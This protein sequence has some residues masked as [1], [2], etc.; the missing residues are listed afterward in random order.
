MKTKIMVSMLVLLLGLGGAGFY[1]PAGDKEVA[2]AIKVIHEVSKKTGDID[3]TTAKKGDFLFSGDQVRT[4]A[5]SIA[6]VKFKDNS[7]LRVRE[8]TELK[9]YAEQKDGKLQKNVNVTRGQFTF[10]IQKQENEV[11][12]FTSPT[13]VAA[14]RGTAGNMGFNIDGDMI[15]VLHGLVNLFNS[16]SK[17]AVDVGE[18]QTG[19]S[20]KDGTIYVR[21]A[22]QNEKDDA[23]NSLNTSHDRGKIQELSLQLRDKGGNTKHLK[24]QYHGK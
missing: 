6:L 14:I 9:I 18:G 8:N 22:S 7:I 13:S 4:L 23:Q 24:I 15:T 17:N 12:T 19:V 11:F 2:L 10:D 20:N 16:I 1:M 5:R 21:D 3:W